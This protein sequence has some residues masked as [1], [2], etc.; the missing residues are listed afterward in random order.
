[1]LMLPNLSALPLHNRHCN[2]VLLT[3]KSDAL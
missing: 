1:M 3:S 2:H